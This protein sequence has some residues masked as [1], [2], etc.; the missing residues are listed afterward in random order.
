[1]HITI[2]V[3][4]AIDLKVSFTIKSSVG[5]PVFNLWFIDLFANRSIILPRIQLLHAPH[6]KALEGLVIAK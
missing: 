4:V 5:S 6:L 2:S 1:V 3:F